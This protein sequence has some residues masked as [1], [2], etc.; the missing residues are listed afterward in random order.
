MRNRSWREGFSIWISSAPRY[1]IYS[2]WRKLKV[3]CHRGREESRG[4]RRGERKRI[5]QCENRTAEHLDLLLVD[6]EGDVAGGLVTGAAG[7][8]LLVPGECRVQ[9]EGQRRCHGQGGRSRSHNSNRSRRAA[10]RCCAVQEKP[11]PPGGRRACT[12]RVPGPAVQRAGV[13]SDA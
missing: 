10:A 5:T 8:V 3:T 11:P 9:E 7:A 1:S 12:R 13:R 6:P 2:I 4:G